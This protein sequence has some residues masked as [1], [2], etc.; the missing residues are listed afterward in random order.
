MRRGNG[1]EQS[2]ECHGFV[3]ESKEDAILIASNLYKSLMETMKKQ[4]EDNKEEESRPSLPPQRPPRQRKAK[5]QR[6]QQQQQRSSED[7]SSLAT[8]SSQ[9]AE[10]NFARAN[11]ND[12]DLGK[13]KRSHSEKFLD[14]IPSRSRNRARRSISERRSFDDS[15]VPTLRRAKERR[16]GDIYTKVAM[17]RSKSF[18]NV[19]GP[20]NLQ[21]LFRELKEKE[22]I[23]SVDDILRQ[24]VSADGMSFNGT[25]P[26]YRELLMKLAMSMSADEM[27]IRSKN[28]IMQEKLKKVSSPMF[29]GGGGVALAAAAKS[30]DGGLGNGFAA[31]VLQKLGVARRNKGL[32]PGK[33]TKADI[34]EP[35][36]LPEETKRELTKQW[37]RT[38]PHL[39]DVVDLTKG[40]QMQQQQHA[41]NNSNNNVEFERKKSGVGVAAAVA[42]SKRRSMAAAAASTTEG[43][44]ESS[45]YMS[46][47]E[48]GYQSVCG[49]NCCSCSMFATTTAA[50]EE[51]EEDEEDDDEHGSDRRGNKK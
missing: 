31:R 27:F 29:G 19:S 21:E 39:S 47:S 10:E 49:T 12:N 41:S 46:C 45:V 4:Q 43:G 16:A 51:D 36:P 3:C 50:E 1:E 48:C 37:M 20:Y 26:V 6:G 38:S 44:G 8:A 13:V 7:S 30:N 42:S 24:V 23:E 9:Q 22:G 14:E 32:S 25:S 5:K 11:S 40:K 18:M 35:L 15:D 33:V 17:P 28:I 34:G 2:L